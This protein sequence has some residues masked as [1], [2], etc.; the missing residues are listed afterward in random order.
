MRQSGDYDDLF[1]W[2]EEDILPLFEPTE[3]LLEKISALI[4]LKKET[5]DGE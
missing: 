3:R 1:D 4:T 5:V 2:A